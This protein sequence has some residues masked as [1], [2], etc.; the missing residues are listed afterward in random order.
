MAALTVKEIVQ[1]TKGEL[2]K[3]DQEALIHGVTIDSRKVKSG[4]LFIPLVGERFDGHSFIGEVLLHGAG[5]ILCDRSKYEAETIDEEQCVILVD[6]TLKAMHILAKYYMSKFDIPV[7][8]VTGSTGK[9]STKD[10][11][12]AVLSKKYNVLRNQGNFN[13]HIGLPLTMFQMEK[14]HEVAVFEMGM[15]G[16]GE[17]DLL[18]ELVR[19]KIAVISN[20]GLSHIE[21]LG[22]Q[23]NIMKAK[24]EIT[25]YFQ[26]GSRLIVNGDDA[27]L[28]KLQQKEFEFNIIYIGV[29]G[30][31]NYIAENIQDLGEYGSQFDLWI[32][33]RN[34]SFKLKVP[35]KH[36][37]YNALMAIAIGVEMDVEMSFI[38]EA[39]E[40]F[41]GSKMRLNIMMTKEGIKIINDAYNASPDSMVSAISVLDKMIANRKIACLG[42]MLEM[43]EYTERGHYQV[44]AEIMNRQKIDML[45]TVG[46]SAQHI[47][48]GAKEHG[49]NEEQIFLC[50]DNHE[51]IEI[52]KGILKHGDAV[53]IK[54][55]RGMKM[56]EI[57][58][59]IQERS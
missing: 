28:A 39:L 2:I 52:L 7:I 41:G 35:G 17:I 21:H 30:R 11:I 20:I 37:I 38:Q 6:D 27:Y 40:E 34:Y 9:T 47:A 45:V 19:P 23:E 14:D 59:Y 22:S 8:G 1:A 50:Q 36:N 31:Y 4:E 55:S 49:F 25:N 15:S 48:K 10:M 26:K 16:F 3:G 42:D 5:G 44:G 32:G 29:Y 18:A 53:L 43:G 58:E 56:E 33:S 46:S 51:A 54:G 12:Y 57:V 24:M 13:N